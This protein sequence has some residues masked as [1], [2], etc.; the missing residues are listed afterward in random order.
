[1]GISYSKRVTKRDYIMLEL[2]LQRD[3]LYRYQKNTEI[4]TL[5]TKEAVKK[6]FEQ[7][8]KQ[9]CLYLLKRKKHYQELFEKACA[10]IETVENLI[11]TI[12]FALIEEDIICIL[13]Q[14]SYLL[15]EIHKGM[16]L[17]SVSKLM[18]QTKDSIICQ[19]DI[20]LALSNTSEDKEDFL[21]ELEELQLYMLPNP[22]ETK[23][24][25]KTEIVEGIL[26]KQNNR[27]QKELSSVILT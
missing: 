12:E 2:K 23:I 7:G 15:K 5:N 11:S 21:K 18:D 4:L 13:R 16:S 17:E 3:K 26:D 1:M 8:N 9:K 10:H 14:S 25:N 24:K 22:P 27:K 20:S 6:S 19:N